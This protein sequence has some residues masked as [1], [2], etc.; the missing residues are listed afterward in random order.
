[1]L[2]LLTRL[3]R[4]RAELWLHELEAALDGEP[5]L[6]GPPHRPLGAAE[7]GAVDILL[8]ANPE[9]GGWADWPGVRLI[10]SLWAGVDGLLADSTLPDLPIARLVDPALAAAMAET[11]ATHVLALHRRLPLY[12]LQQSTRL[13]RQWPQP[14]ARDRRVGIL[15]LGE[16]G[17]AAARLLLQ[18]GFAVAGWSRGGA[19]LEGVATHAGPD[20]LAPLLQRSEILVNLLPLTEATRGI[21]NARTFALLPEG[22]S[23][24]NLGR[25]PHLVVPDLLAAL[26]SGHLDHAVLDVFDQEPLPLESPL[27]HHP[28]LTILPHVAAVTDPRAA[29]ALVAANVRAFR[30]GHPLTGLVSRAG[31]Y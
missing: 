9:P 2:A 25:G 15:G 10:Q 7:R 23:I 27:W 12:R 5:I 14:A 13:W 22:A 11:V 24:V 20:G 31:G 16:M 4:D 18:L 19:A 8:V 28:K 29:A 3:P 17:R 30:E 21:L 6:L 1:M 26:G